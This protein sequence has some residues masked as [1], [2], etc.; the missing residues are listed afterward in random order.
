MK[1]VLKC[2]APSD[3]RQ[4]KWGDFHV[5]R[6]LTKYLRRAGMQVET[7]YDPNWHQADDADVVL[8]LRGKYDHPVTQRAPGARHVM[9]NISHPASVTMEEYATYDLVFIASDRH[10]RDVA[11]RVDVPCLPLLQATDPEEFFPP[12]QHGSRSDFIFVGN[13]RDELRPAVAWAADYGLPLKIWGRGWED[14][15]DDP[16]M[17]VRGAYIPNEE[18]GDRYRSAR[19]TL[20]DHWPDMRAYGFV[21]NR[22]FDSI[23]CGLPVISDRHPELMELGLAGVLSYDGYTEFEACLEELLLDYPR[24]LAAAAVGSAVVR[25]R[26]SFQACADEMIARVSSLG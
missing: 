12:E 17:V 2:P 21:N 14:L 23:A 5:A 11:R 4:R 18:L 13:T 19:A 20:N 16:A 22:V 25:D 8:V 10:A 24:L 9:W 6:S 7:H 26:F 1:W 3:T 15:F